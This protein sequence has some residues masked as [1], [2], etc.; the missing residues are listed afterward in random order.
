MY[1]P[2]RRR[3]RYPPCHSRN[4]EDCGLCNPD[5]IPATRCESMCISRM[6]GSFKT[7][8]QVRC[9]RSRSGSGNTNFC[10]QHYSNFFDN[11]THEFKTS[12]ISLRNI[13]I[14]TQIEARTA[15]NSFFEC[16]C[17]VAHKENFPSVLNVQRMYPHQLRKLFANFMQNDRDRYESPMYSP[18]VREVTRF[19]RDILSI[20]PIIVSN[21]GLLLNGT[22]DHFLP[23]CK[24]YIIL[25]FNDD[26]MRYTLCKLE[27]STKH[28]FSQNDTDLIRT[29]YN[30]LPESG[31]Q[32][33]RV[34][35]NDRREVIY[36]SSDESETE[37]I[38]ISD[39]DED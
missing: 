31:S 39:S 28:L 18:S 23:E 3:R 38:V 17:D 21:D 11:H 4:Q 2:Y 20:H 35:F 26:N 30:S 14:D 19:G 27:M 29:W 1:E 36:V 25:S 6:T 9:R 10:T 8:D 24:H 16:L 34:S 22:V 33:R 37:V 12:N 13:Q 15:S 32:S 5:E 7:R